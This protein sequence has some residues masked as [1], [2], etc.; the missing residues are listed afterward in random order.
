MKKI[1]SLLLSI[2]TIFP[3]TAQDF[4][5]YKRQQQKAFQSYKQKSQEDWDA[6]RR[7]A[8][9]EFVKYLEKTWVKKTGQKPIEK[10]KD[11]PDVPPVVLPEI[12][13]LFKFY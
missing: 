10:P 11:V 5:S 8:N 4:N 2:L 1:L 9:E 13:K 6:Y 12:E 3:A 7:K